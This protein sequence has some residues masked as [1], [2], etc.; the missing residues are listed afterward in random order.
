M[1][2][3]RLHGPRWSITTFHSHCV[4]EHPRALGWEG[5][6]ACSF[7]LNVS[8][9]V[10]HTK[11]IHFLLVR[12]KLHINGWQQGKLRDVYSLGGHVS[13]QNSEALLIQRKEKQMWEQEPVSVTQ[14]WSLS[15][16]LPSRQHLL[17]LIIVS[18]R[19]GEM[20]W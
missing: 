16:L 7:P 8:P 18:Q 2:L 12:I 5:R 20:Q 1:V 9:E 4:R 6:R 3:S 17:L 19:P 10:T 14:S 13:G 15:V 11:F